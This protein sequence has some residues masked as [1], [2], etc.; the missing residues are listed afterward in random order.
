MLESLY[1]GRGQWQLG[2]LTHLINTEASGYL[3]LPDF[4]H[5]V[6]DPS[7]RDV[8]DDSWGK[9]SPAG[10]KKKEKGFYDDED[11]EEEGSSS[12]GSGSDF[13]SS[14]SGSDESGTEDSD[15]DSE[16]GRG[17]MIPRLFAVV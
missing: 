15:S 2:S 11:S 16:E 5:E 10:R 3:P 12:S 4:P 13:Y 7:V 6:P 14:I 8:E 17:G 9:P 1:K